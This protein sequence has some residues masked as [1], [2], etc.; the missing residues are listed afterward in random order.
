MEKEEVQG[1]RKRAACQAVLAKYDIIAME[2]CGVL[3]ATL[4]P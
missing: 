2:N 3:P 4:V 1:S